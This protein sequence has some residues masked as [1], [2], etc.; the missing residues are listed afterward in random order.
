MPREGWIA[1]TLGVVFPLIV[2]IGLMVLLFYSSRKGY[3]SRHSSGLMIIRL[4]PLKPDAADVAYADA[5]R[6]AAWRARAS[7]RREPRIA[8]RTAPL[9]VARHVAPDADGGVSSSSCKSCVVHA[10][11]PHELT[12]EDG[13]GSSG[14]L[15]G[16]QD[17]GDRDG[18]R[19]RG[20]RPV[21]ES[22]PM[23][24]SAPAKTMMIGVAV[25]RPSCASVMGSAPD[26]AGS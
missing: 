13:K 20:H 10:A 25:R 1:L 22:T 11:P 24:H 12:C 7:D 16:E 3:D 21:V 23:R 8:S 17:Q 2:G 4:R 9:D 15:R 14:L 26:D 18:E 6:E 19:D 5:G